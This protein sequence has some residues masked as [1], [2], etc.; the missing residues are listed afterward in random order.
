MAEITIQEVRDFLDKVQGRVI[1]LKELRSEFQLMPG[2][3]SWDS[4]RKMLQR[5]S[6]EK[7]VSPYGKTDGVYKVIRRVQPVQVFGN[8]RERRPPFELFFPK[9]ADTGMEMEFAENIIMREGD[10]ITLGGDK[11]VGK[12]T[13]CLSFCAENI[14]RCPVLMG[15]EY[16]VLVEDRYEPAPRFQNRLD[17]MRDWVEWTNGDGFDKFTLLPVREDYAEHIVQG[18]INIIDWINLAGDKQYDIGKILEN[19][20]ANLGRG[21]AIVALQKKQGE[22]NPRG[23]QFV[24]DFSD[25]ELILDPFGDNDSDVLLTI[26]GVKEKTQPI[27]GKK[28]AYTIV[29]G[30]TRIIDFREVER[31]MDCKGTGYKQSI[32]CET[33]LGRKYKDK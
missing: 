3:K 23:G 8:E 15:N 1:T 26:K 5:L 28:Y 11:S 12:T 18:K 33:C 30:G 29:K 4:L 25:V 10:L 32:K 22:I 2:G 9:D 21:I 17:I 20:K 16:T 7:V 13:L 6:I 14:D 19:I 31:C 24:R 27:V